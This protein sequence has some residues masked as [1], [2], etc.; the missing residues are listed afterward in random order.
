MT[1]PA[2]RF[3]VQATKLAKIIRQQTWILFAITMFSMAID[4]LLQDKLFSMSKN[5]LSGGLVAWLG[6]YI[7]TKIALRQSGYRFRKQVVHN[8]YIGQM[9]KWLVVLIGF[10]VV[11]SQVQPLKPIWVFVGFFILQVTNIILTYKNS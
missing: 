4:F 2:Q 11:F 6:Y 8:F 9:V 10:A 3:H 1:Q 5:I 7:F